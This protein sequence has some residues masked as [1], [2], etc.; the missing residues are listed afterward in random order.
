MMAKR[1]IAI[2]AVTATL[3]GGILS[4]VFLRKSPQIEPNEVVAY[5]RHPSESDEL[6]ELAI[7][8]RVPAEL[9]ERRIA[10]HREELRRLVQKAV[11]ATPPDPKLVREA[12]REILDVLDLEG[13]TISI[14]FNVVPDLSTRPIDESIRKTLEGS[15]S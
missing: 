10:A 5:F 9:A 13:K 7:V 6:I 8:C 12:R 3:A 15:H 1:L 11:L 14:D 2:I 4:I